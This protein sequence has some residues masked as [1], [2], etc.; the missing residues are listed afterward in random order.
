MAEK[1]H[2]ETN[3]CFRKGCKALA[4]QGYML[5]V[6]FSAD[7][8]LFNVSQFCHMFLSQRKNIF[9]CGK[10]CFPCGKMR[11]IGENR[12]PQRMLLAT[13]FLILPGL[14]VVEVELKVTKS[15]VVVKVKTVAVVILNFKA[16][17]R[18][19]GG[20]FNI[21]TASCPASIGVC[22]RRMH[23]VNNAENV[24]LTVTNMTFN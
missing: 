12:C 4:K 3:N 23:H 22:L 16:R 17:A 15:V 14:S 8:C 2:C 1:T 11:N 9:C 13:C 19:G 20:D 24:C 21:H 7:T 10:Q 18:R 5:P 6:T